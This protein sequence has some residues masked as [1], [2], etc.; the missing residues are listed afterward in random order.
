LGKDPQL[1]GTFAVIGPD[2]VGDAPGV[3]SWSPLKR[4]CVKIFGRL[5]VTPVT[6][7]EIVTVVIRLLAAWF[8]VQA[9]SL[10][11]F[12]STQPAIAGERSGAATVLTEFLL[13]GAVCLLTWRFAKTL[14]ERVTP[15]PDPGDVVTSL[16]ARDLEGVLFRAIGVFLALTALNAIAYAVALAAETGLP[17]GKADLTRGT[18][19]LLGGTCLFLGRA[20]LSRIVH[21]VRHGGDYVDEDHE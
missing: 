18:V 4:L 11:V 19:Q 16:G 8:L 9:L 7:I 2:E 6:R 10:L 5:E 20:G 3:P 17:V 21:V 15:E 14:A 1:H 13:L 12:V